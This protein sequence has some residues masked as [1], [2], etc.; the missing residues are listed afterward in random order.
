MISWLSAPVQVRFDLNSSFKRVEMLDK[1]MCANAGGI[2]SA[3]SIKTI[4]YDILIEE[5]V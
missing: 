2:F 1:K 4:S 5:Y 3:L